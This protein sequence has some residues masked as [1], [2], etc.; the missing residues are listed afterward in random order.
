M[1]HGGKI[2]KIAL[3]AKIRARSC[4]GPVT[5]YPV[6]MRGNEKG[7]GGLPAPLLFAAQRMVVGSN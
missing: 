4:A 5:G 7:V 1:G 6:C 2:Q 3:K